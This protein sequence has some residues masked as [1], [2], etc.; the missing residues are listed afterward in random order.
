M[1]GQ[2]ADVNVNV[3]A[4]PGLRTGAILALDVSTPHPLVVAGEGGTLRTTTPVPGKPNQASQALSAAIRNALQGAGLEVSTLA[5]IGCGRGPGTFTGSR[6]GVATAMG[7]AHGLGV[8]VAVVSTLAAVAASAPEEGRVLALL[9]ARRGE[10]YGA[11]FEVGTKMTRIG[12]EHCTPI[13][14]LLQGLPPGWLDEAVAIGPGVAPYR[15]AL[16]PAVAARAIEAPGPTGAGLW[17]AT[18]AAIATGDVADPAAVRPVY[19]RESY[20]QMGVNRPKLPFAPSPF[21]D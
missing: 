1:T 11:A 8:P 4:N 13:D 17:K 5:A 9:D 10:V 14:A 12:P 15:D 16:P 7:L 19:L 3:D 21:L 18:M 20:A 6:V 2:D